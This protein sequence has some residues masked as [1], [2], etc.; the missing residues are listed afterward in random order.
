MWPPL[1]SVWGDANTKERT[2][3]GKGKFYSF[4][5]SFGLHGN[6]IT[7][8][9][10]QECLSDARNLMLIWGNPLVRDEEK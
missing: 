9:D 6:V 2:R 3:T 7:V 8:I 4:K 1:D 10:D 5:L